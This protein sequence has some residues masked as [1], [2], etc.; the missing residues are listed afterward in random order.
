MTTAEARK[1]TYTS[2]RIELDQTHYEA[3][4]DVTVMR[5][6]YGERETLLS[7]NWVHRV[8][9]DDGRVL[10]GP[11][12]ETYQFMKGSKALPG[13][14][15]I[16]LFSGSNSYL[17]QFQS[18]EVY[19]VDDLINLAAAAYDGIYWPSEIDSSKT[20]PFRPYIVE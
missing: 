6:T 17:D 18:D 20:N 13:A 9:T 10:S 11:K 14:T 2:E 15:Y 12:G 7:V 1:D 19:G 4:V 8:R 5:Q 3:W 16:W